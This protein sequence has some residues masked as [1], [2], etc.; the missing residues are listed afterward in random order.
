MGRVIALEHPE[1]WGGAADLSF[2]ENEISD[3]LS[4][5][6]RVKILTFG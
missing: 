2:E 3:L 4:Q 5:A 1:L 6:G